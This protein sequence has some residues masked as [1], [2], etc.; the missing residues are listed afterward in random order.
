MALTV[1]PVVRT[2]VDKKFVVYANVTWD[3]T[4]PAGG[5]ALTANQLGLG[6]IEM[7][8]VLGSVCG[9]A[10]GA[11]F[12]WN[13]STTAPKI[14]A[15]YGD[16]DAV[17]DGLLIEIAVGDTAILSGVVTPIVAIGT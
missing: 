10:T 14:Q 3:A 2:R 16:Y 15:F 6:T 13:G 17:A 8:G 9:A 12:G 5:E 11:A 7:I 4:Y 1:T